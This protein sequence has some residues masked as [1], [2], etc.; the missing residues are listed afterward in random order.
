MV[1]IRIYLRI[2]N[3]IIFKINSKAKY[4]SHDYFI[5]NIKWSKSWNLFIQ[6]LAL[7]NK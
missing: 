6:K 5:S 1:E 7:V 4:T 3:M 2:I